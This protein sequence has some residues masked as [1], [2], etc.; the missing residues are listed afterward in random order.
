MTKFQ[1]IITGL[2]RAHN[3]AVLKG[4]YCSMNAHIFTKGLNQRDLPY[5]IP[6]HKLYKIFD[7]PKYDEYIKN[8]IARACYCFTDTMLYRIP[9]NIFVSDY[10]PSVHRILLHV[11]VWKY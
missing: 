9:S 4:Y 10:C 8:I 6:S 5:K 3:S 7:I 2:A 11:R 1:T